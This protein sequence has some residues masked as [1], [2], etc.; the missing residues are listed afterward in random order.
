VGCNEKDWEGYLKSLPMFGNN[1]FFCSLIFATPYYHWQYA[2]DNGF[3]K[4]VFGGEIIATAKAFAWP[5]FVLTDYVNHEVPSRQASID[6][7]TER[8]LTSFFAAISSV[9]GAQSLMD[10]MLIS[11]NPLSDRDDMQL[12]LRNAQSRLTEVDT[13]VLNSIY[14][15]WGEIV[16]SALIPAVSFLVA[17]IDN[18]FDEIYFA[19]ADAMMVR[20]NNWLNGNSQFLLFELHD[21]FGYEIK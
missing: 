17:G 4:W 13:T 15:G 6:E 21:T 19:R 3:I 10:N 5:Y 11:D 18:D 2:K 8:S 16:D 14:N 12:L 7:A 20:Y 1:I 9:S